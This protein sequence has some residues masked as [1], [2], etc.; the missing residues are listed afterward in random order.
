M[1]ISS[2][3]LRQS[4]DKVKADVA[5]ACAVPGFPNFGNEDMPDHILWHKLIEKKFI[6]DLD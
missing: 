3:F 5:A 1:K 4:L 6:G 2:N